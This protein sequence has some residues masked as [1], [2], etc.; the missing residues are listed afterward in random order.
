MK[1]KIA[2]AMSGGV[3][4]SLTAGMLIEQ[5]Y[6]VIGLTLKLWVKGLDESEDTDA[7]RDAKKM[8]NFFNIPHYVI[9][10]E[11]IFK[12]SVLDYFVNEY[13]NG[14]TPNPC[15]FC[16]RNVKFKL[17]IDKAVELGCSKIVTGHY[18]QIRYN[19]ETNLYEVHKGED[20]KKDQSYVLYLL[21]Q[22]ML[23]K[24]LL[25]LGT[26][27]KGITRKLANEKNLPVANKP[28][29]LDICFLPDNDYKAYV[30][31]KTKGTIKK[32]KIIHENGEVLGTH[33][34]IFNYT[35]GQR[36]G[37]GIAYAYPLY[38][39]KLDAKTNTV[40]VGPNE[41]LFSTDMIC[42]YYNF[43]S[44]TIPKEPFTCEGK[45]RYAAKQSPCKVTILP[46]KQMKVE[47]EKPQRAITPGQS[48]V[49]YDGTH[50]LGG[51]V[52]ANTL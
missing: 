18:A 45:I 28:D 44:G 50:L 35:I 46:N 42:D 14:R 20:E 10:A 17:L 32:G 41:S 9:D 43:M 24:I 22:Y 4:S 47:F 39:V 6:E 33:N 11:D 38:V 2:V 16:N 8:C 48:V 40:I 5:G 27:S 12:E 26:V 29:S 25:P 15:V 3:D 13:K 31:N 7:V 34:G 30:S 19:E 21:N 51:G 1:E 49:L 52:I 23:S 36:K 37:L